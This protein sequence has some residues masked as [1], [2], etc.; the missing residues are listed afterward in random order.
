[1]DCHEA[2]RRLTEELS[3]ETVDTRDKELTLHLATCPE[4]S[5]LAQASLDLRQA[6]NHA[7]TQD[8]VTDMPHIV[9]V[10][11]QTEALA[12]T[13]RHGRRGLRTMAEFWK[14]KSGSLR[15]GI[16]LS[17]AVV[18]LALVTLI[19]FS[20]ERTVGYEVAFA[21]VDPAL[22]MNE[23]RLQ[24]MLEKLGVAGATV[25]LG[26]CEATCELKIS[27]LK[28]MK[29]CKIL[30]HALQEMGNVEVIHEGLPL[31]EDARGGLIELAEHNVFF[32]E[33]EV[34][35]DSEVHGY[36]VECLGEDYGTQMNVWV[37]EVDGESGSIALTTTLDCNVKVNAD[38]E[39]CFLVACGSEDKGTPCCV[40]TDAQGNVTCTP[41]SIEQCL[42]I[43]DQAAS[44]RSRLD[45]LL[46][47][48]GLSMSVLQGELDDE[49]RAKLEAVG[50]VIDLKGNFVRQEG[51]AEFFGPGDNQ[52]TDWVSD[53]DAS[54]LKEGAFVPGR[55]L[56]AQNYP[57]PFNPS[58]NI[59]FTLGTAGHV[60][61]EV[62]NTL[63]QRVRVLTNGQLQAGAH[64][65]AWDARS[66]D[67][68]RVPS[69]AYLYRIQSGDFV[70]SKTMTLL[71]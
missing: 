21:G 20:Y 55:Y 14:N 62:F 54:A 27:D 8:D 43:C 40:Q 18:V 45:E 56:L 28:E 19:P 41:T 58:T 66:D 52:T 64:E 10:R 65:V 30:I 68:Q 7:R 59:S 44:G 70:E 1:M 48:A 51:D 12:D 24:V 60:R 37:H 31:R 47:R 15:W 13:S 6:F 53:E 4:C 25:E 46:Q 34:P 3:V 2:K 63:G 49:T 33:G 23:Y 39:Q 22:A 32:S 67:G 17:A 50:I 38:G 71:K 26:E 16:G 61:L 57:N 35:S 29:E 36:L 11:T 42:Q 69:G 5:A 9:S